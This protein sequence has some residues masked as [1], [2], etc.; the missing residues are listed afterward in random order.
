MGYK[1]AITV[2]PKELLAMVQQYVDGEYLYIP[3]KEETK[4]V[5]GNNTN[6]HMELRVR[7][8][9]IYKDYQSGHDVYELS[10]TYF[11]STKSIQRIVRQQK[12]RV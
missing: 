5:W 8:E 4:R 9:K 2:L 1:K 12:K 11:L 3:R 7:N 6:I 10:E